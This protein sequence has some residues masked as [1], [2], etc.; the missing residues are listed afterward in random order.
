MLLTASVVIP[1]FHVDVTLIVVLA[2]TGSALV[3]VD[4]KLWGP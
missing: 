4:L 3:G 2:I 1:S